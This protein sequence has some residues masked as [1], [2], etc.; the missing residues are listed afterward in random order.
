[1]RKAHGVYYTPD[2]IVRYIVDQTVGRCIANKTPKQIEEMRFAD[3]AC[4]SGGFLEDV[5]SILIRYHLR[6]YIDH[7]AANWEKRGFLRRR[8]TDGDY[9]LTLAEKRRILLNNIYGIDI[10]PQAVEVT[11]LS[12]YLR[13]LEDESFPSTQLLFDIEHHALLPDLR[14]NIIRGNSLIETDIADLFGLTPEEE[15][16]I[17]PLDIRYAFKNIKWD[18]GG[19]MFDAVV[20][21]PP[22]RMLQPHNTDESILEY[23]RSKFGAAEFKIDLFHLF[24]QRAIEAL[25][26]DGKVGYI[27]PS[28]ILNN[29]YAE[30]L[31]R[32]IA[33]RCTIDT[34]AVSP[35]RVFA[36][37]DV[38]TA[39]ITLSRE[40]DSKRRNRHI[41]HTTTLLTKAFLQERR[42]EGRTTQLV[43]ESLPGAVW[44]LLINDTNF[45]VIR[46]L[47]CFPPLSDIADVNRGLITGDRAK[48]FSPKRLTGSHVPILAGGDVHRYFTIRPSEF[49]LFKRPKTAGGCWDEE[50]HFAKHKIVIRQ[51]GERATAA[52]LQTPLAVTGNVFTIRLENLEHEKFVLGLLNSTLIAWFWRIMFSDF[53]TSFPQ[54]TIFSLAQVPI[55]V[56]Q[57]QSRRATELI[58]LVNKMLAAKKS[59]AEKG[60]RREHWAR[61]CEALD[62]QIDA[63]VYQLY[64][65]TD[66]EIALVEQRV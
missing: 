39:V 58:K 20:G 4:G 49:V 44:N 60:A 22:Y 1:V 56:D 38:H 9:V 12:L 27:V 61:Q 41:V 48:Y 59:E 13:L 31:R 28:T 35:E 36:D 63:I 2:Y 42:F 16:E 23:L 19:G 34:I 6:W 52:L 66:R 10:D 45:P 32:F 8:E 53:K 62:R 7:G 33:E 47:Q 15:E 3:I 46:K 51:I 14:D 5:F 18:K 54:V 25:L 43:Y 40:N 11:Q 29:V 55:P 57:F 37:A 50:V 65:L 17:R 64:G 26:P 21:N 24:L 30:T